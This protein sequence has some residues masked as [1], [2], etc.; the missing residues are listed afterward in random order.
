[1]KTLAKLLGCFLGLALLSG[2]AMA[3][4]VTATVIGTISDPS[5]AAVTGAKIDVANLATGSVR[6]VDFSDSSGDFVVPYCPPVRTSL[7][8]QK[9]GSKRRFFRVSPWKSTREPVW[10]SA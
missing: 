9:Q 10:T 3:Q 8:L 2:L 6:S 4:T 7:R 5:G 1:M